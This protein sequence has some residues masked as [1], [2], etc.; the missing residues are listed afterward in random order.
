MSDDIQHIHSCEQAMNLICEQFGDE[1]SSERC[2]ELK[3]H[4]A[5]CSDCSKY[6]DS[7]GRMIEFYRETSPQL[8]D[9]AR[10]A[11]LDSLGIADKD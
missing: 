1:D 5:S 11:I 10:T 2:V 4:I 6:C 7:I 9:E 8:S 3:K